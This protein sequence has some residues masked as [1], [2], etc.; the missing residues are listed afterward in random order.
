[1]NQRGVGVVGGINAS[2]QSV[3]RRFNLFRLTPAE[4]E[5]YDHFRKKADSFRAAMDLVKDD[6]EEGHRSAAERELESIFLNLV[7]P[8]FENIRVGGAIECSI[9]YPKGVRYVKMQMSTVPSVELHYWF[10]T[11]DVGL[12]C[13]SFLKYDPDPRR[14]RAEAERRA[15]YDI[16][17]RFVSIQKEKGKNPPG[18]IINQ[19]SVDFVPMAYSIPLAAKVRNI[20]KKTGEESMEELG[21]LLTYQQRLHNQRPRGRMIEVLEE[22]LKEVYDSRIAREAGLLAAGV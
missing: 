21:I 12:S 18:L 1:M 19:D 11:E 9:E 16:L 7:N 14:I 10:E 5:I 3:E 6:L 13:R 15:V 2:G 8:Y 22:A 20:V 4:Q 17:D